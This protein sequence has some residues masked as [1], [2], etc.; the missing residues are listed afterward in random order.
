MKDIGAKYNVCS[1][2]VS[3]V[4]KEAEV[5]MPGKRQRKIT[6]AE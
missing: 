1:N 4:L 3:R 2:T 5:R 6:Y